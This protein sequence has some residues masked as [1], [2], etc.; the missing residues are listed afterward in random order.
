MHERGRG[1]ALSP[2]LRAG[3]LPVNSRRTTGAVVDQDGRATIPSCII[4]PRVSNPSHSSATLPLARRKMEMPGLA[5]PTVLFRNPHLPPQTR[6]GVYFGAL[7]ETSVCSESS[8]VG[9][10]VI[11]AAETF[12]PFLR[13][14]TDAGLPSTMNL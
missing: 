3:P 13:S 2:R 14:F 5:P 11:L 1:H 4:M 7:P 10:S 6:R 12:I 8:V 9:S